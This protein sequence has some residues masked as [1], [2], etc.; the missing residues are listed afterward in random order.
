MAT[1]YAKGSLS[2]LGEVKTG[3]SKSGKDWARQTIM[4]DIPGYQ[5]TITK[6]SLEVSMDRIDDVAAFSLG[7][8]VEIGFKVY[9]REYN[10]KWYNNVDLISIKSPDAP[11]T[12]RPK[13]APAPKNNPDELN[14]EAHDDLPW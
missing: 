12:A 2:F 1:Y 6:L 5:G 7:E 4:I 11:Q 13:S 3:T 9:A 10:G 14:P 8:M